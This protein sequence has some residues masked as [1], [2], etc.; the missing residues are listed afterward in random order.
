LPPADLPPSGPIDV[1]LVPLQV[2]GGCGR[3]VGSLGPDEARHAASLD[4]D[5]IRDR[6]V[7]CRAALRRILAARL[8]RAPAEL[9]FEY[10]ENGKPALAGA[11]LA[12]NL[13]HSGDLA[14]IGVAASGA[15]GVDLERIDAERP[16]DV[17][18]LARRVLT[19]AERAALGRAPDET[20]RR[21]WFHRC[22]TAKEATAKAF[23]TGLKLAL[24][25]LEVTPAGDDRATV[26]VAPADGGRGGEPLP[27]GARP[28]EVRWSSPADGYLAALAGGGA[29]NERRPPR[30]LDL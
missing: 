4:H 17:E 21:Q 8:D 13:S 7:V 14:L 29:W 19:E 28:V 2:E 23:G 22:W 30:W 9:R 10:G 24:Q 27:D 1:W 26:A 6:Y 15:V 5:R 12:F 11:E 16:A 3:L 25:R 18:L 20:A